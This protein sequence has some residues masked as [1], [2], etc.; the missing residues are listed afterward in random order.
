MERNGLIAADRAAYFEWDFS[1]DGGAVGDIALRGDRLPAGVIITGGKIH[2][3]TAVTGGAGA[4]LSLAVGLS[5]LLPDTAVADLTLDAILDVVPN[6]AAANCILVATTGTGVT[7]TI[8]GA[9]MTAGKITLAL[10]YL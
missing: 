7:L 4:V 2:V 8:A 9:A 10:Q 5:E 1:R 3:N 6:N